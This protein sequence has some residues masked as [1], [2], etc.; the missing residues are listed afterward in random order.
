MNAIDDEHYLRMVGRLAQRCFKRQV[1]AYG[2]LS[3]DFL[4]RKIAE[5]DAKEDAGA[6]ADP[7]KPDTGDH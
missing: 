7:E 5:C 6:P 3:L 4:A 1:L 2:K